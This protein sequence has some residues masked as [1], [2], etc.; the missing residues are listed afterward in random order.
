MQK[1]S[2]AILF[3]FYTSDL[4]SFDC[5]GFVILQRILQRIMQISDEDIFGWLGFYF[6]CKYMYHWML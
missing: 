6:I 4:N 3:P 5:Y 2:S 1:Y